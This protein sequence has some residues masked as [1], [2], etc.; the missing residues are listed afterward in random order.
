ND[1]MKDGALTSKTKELAAIALSIAANC[2][3][4]AA[5]RGSKGRNCRNYRRCRPFAWRPGG[6]LAF[7]N[8]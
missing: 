3:T 6:C 4:C 1:V 2:E 5:T 7:K 8:Y